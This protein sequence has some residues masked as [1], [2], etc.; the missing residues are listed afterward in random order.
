MKLRFENENGGT[1]NGAKVTMTITEEQIDCAK[2]WRG[3]PDWAAGKYDENNQKMMRMRVKKEKKEQEYVLLSAEL[4]HKPAAN[5]MNDGKHQA[6]LDLL[7]EQL[8]QEVDV[9]NWACT[10]LH[11]L[12]ADE[13]TAEEEDKDAGHTIED[14]KEAA[15]QPLLPKKRS[16]PF[17]CFSL[18]AE[19]KQDAAKT[20]KIEL[21]KH[22]QQMLKMMKNREQEKK[23]THECLRQLMKVG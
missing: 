1:S 20:E 15:K 8:Q 14:V 18:P 21:T 19:G 17:C 23:N 16:P 9:M 11:E 3:L 13:P 7:L 10:K 12:L 22:G 6:A 5:E 4:Q 2:R